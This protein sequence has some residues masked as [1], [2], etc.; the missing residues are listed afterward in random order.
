LT[1][2][3]QSSTTLTVP[4]RLAA[5]A[6]PA[7][8]VGTIVVLGALLSWR[9][10]RNT[11]E[12]FVMTD[13][14][15]Y[16]NL[17]R[18]FGDGSF[19]LPTLRG[20]HTALLSFLYP[21]LLA[22]VVALRSAPE[23]F[24]TIHAV[25]ALLVSSTAIPVY[26]LARQVVGRRWHAYLAAALAVA[27]PW[28]ATTGVVMTESAAYPAFA[29]ALLAIQRAL[30]VPSLR[31]DLIAL[32]GIGLAFFARTQFLFLAGAF[33]ALIVLHE[34]LF[35][36]TACAQAPDRDAKLRLLRE[37]LR[38]HAGLGALIVV[39]LLLVVFAGMLER[40]LGP[41]QATVHE[42]GVLPASLGPAMRV[43]LTLVAGGLGILPVA[44]ATGW[45]LSSLVRPLDRASHAFAALAL[46]VGLG[47]VYVVAIFGVRH[48]GGPLDRYLFYIAPL[49]IVATVAC[50]A[51]GRPRPFGLAAGAAFTFWLVRSSGL[52]F[53]DTQ[54]YVSS[55]ASEFHR[56]IAGQA[57][58]LGR[59]SPVALLSWGTLVATAAVAL[60][61]HRLPRLAPA[62]VG[63]P[64]LGL[65]IAQTD[66]VCKARTAHVN[67]S[68]GAVDAFPLAQRDWIDRAL[69]AAGAVALSPSP[70]AELNATQQVWW[71]VEFW[72][73]RI[74][75]AQTLD[76]FGDNTP[77]PSQD[78]FLDER[79]GSIRLSHGG[80][81]PFMVFG[82]NQI[83]FRL[84]GRLLAERK[85]TTIP[86]DPG[87]ELWAVRR[88]Y[89]AQWVA[90]GPSEDGWIVRGTRA[91]LRVFPREDGRAQRVQLSF[92]LPNELPTPS[93]FAVREGTR[94]VHGQARGV[95][96]GDGEIAMCL[97]PRRLR[98]VVI[99]T[100]A[101]RLFYGR[102]VGVHLRAIRVGPAGRRC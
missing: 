87:L 12:W 51:Q 30:V 6:H 102:R 92:N 70:L 65:A 77:F 71:N 83:V 32:A 14:L 90:D 21:L 55:Q 9:Y 59:L 38:P 49:V 60:L 13:E 100:R 58:R 98:T 85:T 86:Q 80:E 16:L 28:A 96:G 63:V 47:M 93:H 68:Y 2:T 89:R 8:V 97:A 61:L 40:L 35:V 56:V 75:R 31:R 4:R 64:L 99:T 37:R 84:R 78:L 36:A 25:N 53:K 41:F 62:L 76:R 57:Y 74:N 15:Q 94:V 82:R 81:V 45:A 29:W 42:G 88:P 1:A 27:V 50:L 10:T 95:V 24:Q 44:L 17:A 11:H 48:A 66:Y 43:Q 67:A 22:P 33:P 46:V 18:S 39:A 72:N 34:L 91:R 79:D 52:T 5:V 19:P 26:L 73:K 20:E 23:A 3:T 7:V 101:N 69:P 54:L